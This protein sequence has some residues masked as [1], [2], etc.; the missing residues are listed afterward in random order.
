MIRFFE[1]VEL[2]KQ[3]SGLKE[4]G[5]LSAWIYQL[6]NSAP[7]LGSK[8]INDVHIYLKMG[9][10]TPQQTKPKVITKTVVKKVIRYVK[11]KESTEQFVSKWVG[12][13]FNG[14]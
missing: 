9:G 12:E 10:K 7:A 5:K 1:I 4:P 3:K 6:L 2:A 8:R 11:P 14:N 13:H